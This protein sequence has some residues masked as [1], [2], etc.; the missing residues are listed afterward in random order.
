MGCL[1]FFDRDFEHLYV[2]CGVSHSAV[3][4]GTRCISYQ[5]YNI[6]GA[7]QVTRAEFEFLPL[8]DNC[9]F[10]VNIGAGVGLTADPYNLVVAVI[11]L[12]AKLRPFCNAT[13]LSVYLTQ[14]LDGDFV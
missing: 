14:L 11:G 8:W 1:T 2:V 5:F 4:D 6:F 9:I 3:T 12:Y 13:V 10:E 7:V